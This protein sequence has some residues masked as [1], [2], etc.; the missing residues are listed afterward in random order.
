MN[1]VFTSLVGIIAVVALV[2][3]VQAYSKPVPVQSVKTVVVEKGAKG[4]KGDKG[5]RGEQ[6]IAGRDGKVSVGAVTGPD[7]YFPYVANNDLQKWGQTRGL[8]TATTTV[9]AIQSP[10]STSTLVFGSVKF[11]VGTTTASTVTLAKA[12][13]AFA[14][15]TVL[16]RQALATSTQGTFLASSTSLLASG[17]INDNVFAPNQWFVVAMEG[18]TGTFSPTGSCS[19]EFVRN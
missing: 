3:G 5:D 13:T 11:I 12:A 18:G 16:N 9:C 10:V 7:T 15:T 2:V 6:G 8:S 4:D 14:T 19:A 1:K 17:L